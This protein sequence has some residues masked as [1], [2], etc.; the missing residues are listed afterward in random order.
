MVHYSWN[1]SQQNSREK[2]EKKY[3]F[4]N[5]FRLATLER[6]NDCHF[7]TA[8]KKKKI[9]KRKDNMESSRDHIIESELIFFWIK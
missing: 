1:K 2:E 8:N 7:E 3:N 6:T 9:K 4:H 5:K